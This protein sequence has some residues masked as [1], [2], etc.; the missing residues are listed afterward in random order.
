[1]SKTI[2]KRQKM[3][4]ELYQDKQLSS[5]IRRPNRTS[6]QEQNNH[7][8]ILESRLQLMEESLSKTKFNSPEFN[9]ILESCVDIYCE[10]NEDKNLD[11]NEI[12]KMAK[13]RI[14]KDEIIGEFDNKKLKQ[15][16]DWPFMGRITLRDAIKKS[17]IGQNPNSKQSKNVEDTFGGKKKNNNPSP[18]SDVILN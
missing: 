2:K 12:V 9:S 13:D 18:S 15:D 11:K 6:E 7:N 17:D 4:D 10:L 5:V 14:L 1:M 8:F 16:K 3:W